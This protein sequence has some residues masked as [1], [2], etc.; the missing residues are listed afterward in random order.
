VAGRV[1]LVFSCWLAVVVEAAGA[2]GGNRERLGLG[3][4]IKVG[5]KAAMLGF[6]L[7]VNDDEVGD[8]FEFVGVVRDKSCTE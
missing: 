5:E 6:A 7:P 3:I 4:K 1:F 2:A 8:A